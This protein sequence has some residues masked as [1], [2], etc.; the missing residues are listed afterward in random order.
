MI[1]KTLKFFV[2]A[3]CLA[4][5]YITT[6]LLISLLMLASVS[7]AQ[8]LPEEQKR[9]I[10]RIEN[11]DGV[12]TGFLLSDSLRGW[13]LVT[14]KH[15]LQSSKTH[16]YFDSVF[17]RKNKLSN[18]NKVIATNEKATLYLRYKGSNLFVEHPDSNVDLVIVGLG[19]ILPGDTTVVNPANYTE[20]FYGFNMSMVANRQ[21]VKRLNIGDGT[22]VQIIGFSFVSAQQPQFHISRFGHIA[23]FPSGTVTF[24]V[25]KKDD[26]STRTD[27]VTSEWIVIDL[28]S[29]PGDSGGP[30][31]AEL[32]GTHEAWLIGFVT[33]DVV[34]D[35]LCL[36]QPSFYIWDLVDLIKRRI[37][38]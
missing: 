37:T 38:K 24:A 17:V 23:I 6:F 15:M 31:F 13:F 11:P 29:R 18:D 2:L 34:L 22:P 16:Q 9:S 7:F 36:A 8:S 25:K 20:W 4:Q 19:T 5:W 14:N 32:P 33:A 26:S 35:E 30:V 21:D 28:T 12:G 1:E 10:V 27:S 3:S